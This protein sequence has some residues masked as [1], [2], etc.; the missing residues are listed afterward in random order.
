[1]S[2]QPGLHYKQHH[3][4]DPPRI[5]V[6]SFRPGWRVRSRLDVLY[7]DGRL[8]P[9]ELQAAVEYRATWERVLAVGRGSGM[10]FD[11]GGSGSGSRDPLAG[12]VD[13]VERLRRVEGR[14]GPVAAQLCH[15][16]AVL[17]LPW[18]QLARVTGRDPHTVRDWAVLAL[19]ALAVAWTSPTRRA[20]A[21]APQRGAARAEPL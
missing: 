15:C 2:T 6:R 7:R 11:R 21:A 3:D 5:D 19:R 4:V 18:A 12:I 17:D 20:G 14:I 16:C 1:M 8:T 13:S 10:N 9:G